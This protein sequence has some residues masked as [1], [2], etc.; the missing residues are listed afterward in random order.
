VGDALFRR[1]GEAYVPSDLGG[2]PWT[3]GFLHG[4]PPSSL[5]AYGIERHVDDPGMQAVRLTFDLFRAIPRAPLHLRTETVRGG[6]RIHVAQASLLHD[7]IEVA[8]AS[9]L[10]LRRSDVTTAA[11]PQS[12]PPGP[13]GYPTTVGIAHK[14]ERDD[15]RPPD[16]F[17]PRF[18][19]FHTSIETRWATGYGIEAPPTVW[20]RVPMPVIEDEPTTPVMRIAAISDFGNAIGNQAL[21]LS[22]TKHSYINADITLYLHRDPDGEWLCLQGDYRAETAGVGFID[23]TWFDQR[24]RFAT[25]VQSRLLNPR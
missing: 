4:G 16:T 9:G 24:G 3:D 22:G 6:R 10:F 23:S 19:G 11:P 17:R 7:G 25:V 14:R 13:E 2:S 12:S 15:G 20:I 18:A 21:G 1:E 5:L 8:R